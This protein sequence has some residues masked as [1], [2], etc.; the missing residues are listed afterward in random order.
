MNEWQFYMWCI[1]NFH[2]KPFVFTVRCAARR[3]ENVVNE[4]LYV[5]HKNK[6]KKQHPS[7]QKLACSQFSAENDNEKVSMALT[8]RR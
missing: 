3:G 1:K 5:G 4:N 7:T 6:A 2:T 8:K